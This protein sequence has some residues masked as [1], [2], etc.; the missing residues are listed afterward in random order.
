MKERIKWAREKRGLSCQALDRKAGL[1][2]GHTAY[3]ESGARANPTG[4]TIV[5]IATALNV[6]IAWLMAGG[7]KP[8]LRFD[9]LKKC[10]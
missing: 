8:K 7:P 3:I 1:S 6:E 5:K 4:D 9:L 10:T 2:P